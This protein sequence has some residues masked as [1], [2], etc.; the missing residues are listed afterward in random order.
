MVSIHVKIVSIHMSTNTKCIDL[1]SYVQLISTLENN[2][3][4]R[5]LKMQPILWKMVVFFYFIYY[6]QSVYIHV[7]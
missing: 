3:T 7:S 4:L 6:N 5:V 2:Y 1:H